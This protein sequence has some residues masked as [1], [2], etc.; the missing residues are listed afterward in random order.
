MKKTGGTTG[1][2]GVKISL[3]NV[4]D[5]STLTESEGT[6]TL[7]GSTTSLNMR[8]ISD[9]PIRCIIKGNTLIFASTAASLNSQVAIFS[10]D[11]KMQDSSSL[12]GLSMEQQRITLPRLIPGI[13]IMQVTIGHD[14]FTRTLVC[15]GNNLTMKNT[16]TGKISGTRLILGKKL[17]D[18]AAVDTLMA[19]KEGY[20]TAKM[21]I[22]SYAMDNI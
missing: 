3:A 6:F 19:E 1:I 11:G 18:A 21:A 5:L 13:Y 15:V 9:E 14:S 10:S 2:G 20:Q 12:D 7:T 4:S 17:S 16:I 8:R 22:Q